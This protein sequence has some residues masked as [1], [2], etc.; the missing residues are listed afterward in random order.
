[1]KN[2]GLILLFA[3]GGLLTS[4]SDAYEIDEK[5]GIYNSD[6]AF[7]NAQDVSRGINAIYSVIPASREV[8]FN[9]VFTDE[10]SIGIENGGQ[11]LIS[12]E[13]SFNMESG[14]SDAAALWNGYYSMINRINRLEVVAKKLMSNTT[15]ADEISSQKDNLGEL[16]ILRAYA[17]YKLFSYFTPNYT[18]GSGP[19]VIKLDHVPP[20]DYGYSIKRS[21]VNEIKQFI[22]D[23]LKLATETRQKGWGNYDYVNNGVIESIRTKL[24]AMT[25]DWDL[26]LQ[27][28]EEVLKQYT[29][30]GADDYAKLFAKVDKDFVEP[31]AGR[32][33]I[34][35]LH[36]TVN[37]GPSPAANWYSV[38]PR[39][40]D[41]SPIYEMG[42]SLYNEL[43]KLDQANTGKD[44]TTGRGD[45]RYQV[46]LLPDL[47]ANY[48]GTKVLTT[49]ESATQSDYTSKDILLIGKYRGTEGS[50]LRNSINLFRVTDILLAMAEARAAKGQFI[51]SS[52]DP[53]DVLNM[54]TDVYSIL[55]T[56]RYNRWLP[57]DISGIDMPTIANSQDAFKA[58][59]NE[60]RVEF[61]FEGHRYLDMKRLG[62]K[63]GSPGFTRYSKDCVINGA[64]NLPVTS[65]K[66]TFPI[67]IGEMNGNKSLTPADQN[68]GY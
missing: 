38:R 32:E 30:I 16:Y 52:T 45:V 49:Y 63:A 54:T 3:I 65:Y 4:C 5:G 58:I 64:C 22:L 11:G 40:G 68:P 13:Y 8:D 28:G 6:E 44:F 25:G 17:H 35:R 15:I 42:R 60:R 43:D 50:N 36:G 55:Y 39:G 12:G 20:Y 14:N 37:S 56:V 31:A 34:F 9:S 7:R 51:G 48:P 61:A 57:T 46:N 47:G 24:Y 18:N 19:S 53:D 62:A 10:V 67:P 59:L 66:M 1:M 41:G 33:V 27:H 29:P 2:K 21:T 26:V 23:D